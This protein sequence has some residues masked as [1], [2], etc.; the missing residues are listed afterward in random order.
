MAEEFLAA[1]QLVIGIFQ[2]PLAQQNGREDIQRVIH[3]PAE[4]A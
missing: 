1:E 4:T 3:R 2:P